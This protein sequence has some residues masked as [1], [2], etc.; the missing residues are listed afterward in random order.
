MKF[1]YFFCVWNLA[2]FFFFYRL[3]PGRFRNEVPNDPM[4][5]ENF[6]SQF[7]ALGSKN[8]FPRAAKICCPGQDEIDFFFNEL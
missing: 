6:C 7:I 3:P 4:A 1:F 5:A 2:N 8:L